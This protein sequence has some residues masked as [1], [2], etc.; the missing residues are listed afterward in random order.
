MRHA[1]DDLGFG[2]GRSFVHLADEMLDHLFGGV[3]VGNHAFAHRADRLDAAGRPAQHQLGVFAHGE[4]LFDT[5]LDVIGD[6][7]RFGQDDALAFYVYQSVSRSEIN[8]HI[9]RKQTTQIS[10][11][12]HARTLR[13]YVLARES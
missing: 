5:V 11:P 9:R 6:N 1:D 12:R 2:K 7:R 13:Q 4:H 10:K 3:K 8:G